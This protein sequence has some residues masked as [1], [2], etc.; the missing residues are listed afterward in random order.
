MKQLII[1]SLIAGLVGF[2]LYKL[3]QSPEKYLKKK[4]EYLIA[5]GSVKKANISQVTKISKYIHHNVQ[6]KVEYE[7]HIFK[8]S[9]LNEFRS[10]VMAYLRQGTGSGDLE[11]KNL[12][13]E[14]KNN[15]KTG[16][17]NFEALFNRISQKLLCKV[18]LEWNKEK[19]WYV[20]KIEVHSCQQSN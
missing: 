1:Y 7:G 15:K 13:V 17:V 19:R 14:I 6:M 11:Y 9:S 20:Q 8:A 4:T 12:T 10:Y 5:L 3:F 2:G 18:A 16:L